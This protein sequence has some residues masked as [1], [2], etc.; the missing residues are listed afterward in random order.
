MTF[1]EIP[2]YRITY[3]FDLLIHFADHIISEMCTTAGWRNKEHHMDMSGFNGWY[4]DIQCDNLKVLKGTEVIASI[5]VASD[6]SLKIDSSDPFFK[7]KDITQLQQAIQGICTSDHNLEEL[8][9]FSHNGYQII[10]GFQVGSRY[11]F[12]DTI[13]EPG[14]RSDLAQRCGDVTFV[15]RELFESTCIA[16]IN[17]L[18]PDYENVQLKPVYFCYDGILLT[19]V[20]ETHKSI[21]NKKEWDLFIKECDEIRVSLNR[22]VNLE[23]RPFQYKTATYPA[24]SVVDLPQCIS[25][26][27]SCGAEYMETIRI[28]RENFWLISPDNKHRFK[29][30]HEAIQHVRDVVLS[31]K[32]I[33]HARIDASTYLK[34]TS[35]KEPQN[36]TTTRRK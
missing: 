17:N 16:Y 18:Q 22:S 21:A 24:K 14:C 7:G 10:F 27:T 29:D 2:G 36:N 1:D 20:L 30:R 31:E 5:C 3:E 15:N 23:P 6:G 12:G 32:N 8:K 11:F 34:R 35:L 25:L 13:K 28:S 4:L 26:L 19:D 33:K 9:K